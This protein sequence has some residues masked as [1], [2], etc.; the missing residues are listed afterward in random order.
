MSRT[1][2]KNKQKLC[3]HI[4]TEHELFLFCLY[5]LLLPVSFY[6]A[7]PPAWCSLYN[8]F[9]LYRNCAVLNTLSDLN[10]VRAISIGI[11]CTCKHKYTRRPILFL[12]TV[13]HIRGSFGAVQHGEGKQGKEADGGKPTEHGSVQ[14]TLNSN[15]L[16]CALD[17]FF[18]R[19][20]L[21]ISL[22]SSLLLS[23]SPLRSP[24]PPSLPAHNFRFF[25]NILLH[26]HLN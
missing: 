8:N 26:F 10:D 11:K 23:S 3:K 14:N 19:C 9:I 20:N 5:L 25:A 13:A 12:A 4:H 21:S 15:M 17:K 22:P 24:P 18:C 6:P 1:K 2:T 7:I 16:S